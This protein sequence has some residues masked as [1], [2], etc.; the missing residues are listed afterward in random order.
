MRVTI[1]V[2]CDEGGLIDD[3][4]DDVLCGVEL[5]EEVLGED[6]DGVVDVV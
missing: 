6:D 4:V 1:V 3:G 5:V 2:G